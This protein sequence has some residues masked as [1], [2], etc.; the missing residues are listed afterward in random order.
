MKSTVRRI[1]LSPGH[2]KGFNTQSQD[3]LL[4]IVVNS[5]LVGWIDISKGSTVFFLL[6]H[7]D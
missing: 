3:P 6:K 2:G 5:K 4:G 1:L 7:L